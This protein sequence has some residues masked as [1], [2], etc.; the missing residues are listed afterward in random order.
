MSRQLD[1]EFENEDEAIMGDIDFMEAGA[2]E[3]AGISGSRLVWMLGGVLAGM[4]L[5]YL[6]DFQSGSRRRSTLVSGVR[7]LSSRVGRRI[8]GGRGSSIRQEYAH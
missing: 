2:D 4:G 1:T 7:N 3:D 6:C 8:S 5:M